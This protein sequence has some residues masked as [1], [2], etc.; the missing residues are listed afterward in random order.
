MKTKIIRFLL[1]IALVFSLLTPST[2]AH[3]VGV[4]YAKPVA[5]GT[6]DCLSWANACILQT[7]LTGAVSSDEIWAAA[8]TYAPGTDRT[9]TFQLKNGVAVYGGFAGTETTRTQRNPAINVT[10]LSGDLNG[11]DVGFTNNGENVLHVVTGATGATLDGFTITA[12]N[13]NGGDCNPGCGGGMININSSPTVTNVIFSGNY[14]F[15]AGGGMVN[16]SSS[17]TLTDVTFNG[18]SVGF[19]GGGMFGDNSSPTLMNVT[20]KGNSSQSGPGGGFY[21]N[22]G[23]NPTLTNVTFSGNSAPN[24]GGGGMFNYGSSPT[25]MNVTFSGN[26]AGVGGGFYNYQGGTAQIR[27]TIFWGNTSSGS[28]AQIFYDH[29]GTPNISDSIMQDG[30]AG[31][32]NII[33]DDPILGT[34]GNYG[35]ST[36][37][38]PI[39]A[40]SSAI[41][42][43][44]DSTCPAT[45]QRGMTRPQGAHCDIGAF[46][47]KGIYYVKPVASGTGDCLG[48][49]NAC[50]LQ[51]GLTSATSGYDIWVAAGTYK[52]TTVSTDR[53]ATF[54]LKNG[55]A[56]YG[57]FAGTE[58]ARTQRDPAAN[59][60]ILSGDIDNN[61]SQA[62]IITD[63]TTVTG[64]TTNSY[65]VVTGTNNAILD[66]FTITAGYANGD[67]CP[68]KDCYGG[69]IYNY[70]SSPEL[71]NIIFSGNWATYGG[72]MFNENSHPTLTNVIFNNNSVQY[73]GGGMFGQGA[74]SPTLS[75]VTFS[76]NAANRGGGMFNH[77][78]SN[79]TLTNV[80]FSGNAATYGGGLYN[81]V[82]S[83]PTLTN[84]TF[85]S[86]SANQGGALYN[87]GSSPTMENV[88]IAGNSAVDHGGG[89]Y[90]ADL[91]YPQF[92]NTIFWG[93]TA[94]GG[95]GAQIYNFSG[96]TT[97]SDSVVQGGCADTS[98]S[99]GT[100]IITADPRLGALGD[101]GGF[102][103]TIPIL[104]GSSAIDTGNDSTCPATDQRGMTR[105]Q[106]AH[107][108]IGAF[109]QDDFTAPTVDTF[110]VTTP[111]NTLN[112]PIPSFT[113]SDAVG[114]S[115]YLITESASVPAVGAAGW[116][117]A[118]PT[119]YTVGSDGS[120]TLYPWAKDAAGNVS[121]VF[122]F[123]R[124]VVVDTIAPTVVSSVRANPSP[125]NLASVNFTVTFSEAVTGVD[126]ADFSLTT[127]GVPGTSVTG[128]S[129]SGSV[130]TVTI[131]TG[132]GN[133]TIRLDVPSSATIADLAGNP[134]AGRPY[135][136]GET[137]TITKVFTI[138][139][140]LILH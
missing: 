118:A 82:G 111:S 7:A 79:P 123:P 26:S 55:V 14:A 77:N 74:S 50:T 6:G 46:E 115:G 9:A 133:G 61:D 66:G 114:V 100:N 52:P 34:L 11:D 54:Q 85:S 132:S 21:N 38:I 87:S 106:G 36:E 73:G 70:S 94:A 126:V 103:Q 23:G 102:T 47:Y 88:T 71:I 110:T 108:D 62:P 2:I 112:I 39:L 96:D 57:G 64:N 116:T 20:F 69:G 90:I 22:P 29:F 83:D 59:L 124:L 68:N 15:T 41:D 97:S 65:N 18:N 45:D 53:S 104:V 30:Y 44:N 80:T 98:W 122:A 25:L 101:Y 1:L 129:G 51:T 63:L 107:C 72:G 95:I 43:G 56:I 60:T 91:S 105:P 35:G 135:T 125:T 137:Y 24:N 5:S 76:G 49:A 119:T 16:G 27:N 131:N 37:T 4:L 128:I 130:Y 33:T 93:N 19:Y 127:T 28:G 67:T 17:P 8:G 140:P 89:M 12:G 109:E 139:L 40:G 121:A 58:T 48:W 32:T 136:A 92:R 99:C 120:Y 42:T 117:G 86:N 78:G 3:A 13:A 75:N 81:Q 10:T 134:L 138:F 113:A 84:V 31:G